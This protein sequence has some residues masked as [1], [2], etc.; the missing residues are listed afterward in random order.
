MYFVSIVPDHNWPVQTQPYIMWWGQQ[1][2]PNTAQLI[3]DHI[4][5]LFPVT[6]PQTSNIISTDL[7][8]PDVSPW[9]CGGPGDTGQS[10]ALDCP[11]VAVGCSGEGIAGVGHGSQVISY[12]NTSLSHNIVALSSPACNTTASVG[13]HGGVVQL[14]SS[15]HDQSHHHQGPG[16]Q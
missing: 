14:S 9:V 11:G 16:M 10:A 13:H 5:V 6:Q 8:V 1:M 7:A 2:H 4:P 15:Y 3:P 12:S